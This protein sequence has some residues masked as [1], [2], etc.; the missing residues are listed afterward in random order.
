MFVAK[1]GASRFS[2]ILSCHESVTKKLTSNVFE[3]FSLRR[4]FIYSYLIDRLSASQRFLIRKFVW[5]GLLLK[6]WSFLKQTLLIICVQLCYFNFFCIKNLNIKNF[7]KHIIPICIFFYSQA[8]ISFH[9]ISMCY[10][11]RQSFE[12]SSN[13]LSFL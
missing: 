9:A 7:Y 5:W 10:H 1:W 11:T 12:I 3:R 6:F 2:S 13:I 8:Y 4:T